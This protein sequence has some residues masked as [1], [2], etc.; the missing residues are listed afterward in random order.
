MTPIERCRLSDRCTYVARMVV[1]MVSLGFVVGVA[2]R[3]PPEE[4][5]PA[6]APS[7]SPLEEAAALLEAGDAD[8]AV[9]VL[10]TIETVL[11]SDAHVLLVEAL[12][13]AGR[14]DE[15][16]EQIATLS[17]E[18]L[19]E[20][21]RLDACGMAALAHIEAE[22][23]EAALDDLDLC[24]SAGRID[25]AVFRHVAEEPAGSVTLGGGERLVTRLREAEPGPH[26]DAAAAVLEQEMLALSRAEED[27]YSSVQM[28]RFAYLVGQDPELGEELRTAIPQAAEAYFD[29]SPQ[30]T[31]SLYESIYSDRIPGMEWTEEERSHAETRMQDALL[32]TMRS[33]FRSRYRQKHYED[34]MALGYTEDGE[35]FTFPPAESAEA[36]REEIATWVY[37]VYERPKPTPYPDF[38]AIGGICEDHTQPCTFEVDTAIDWIFRLDEHEQ[39]RAAE[40]GTELVYE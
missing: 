38:L 11:D 39:A 21:Y 4:A 23:Y 34:D 33:N 37:R 2:C 22:E 28:L 3:K 10:E 17:D 29:E 25:I 30:V 8:G 13:A 7:L 14:Y 24:Q 32:V 19:A 40:V 16:R 36:R 31:A 27:L 26:V 12:L 6:E 18:S 9:S 35:T 5:D 20:A 15:A 1:L